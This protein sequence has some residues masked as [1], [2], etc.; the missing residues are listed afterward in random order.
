MDLDLAS[1]GGLELGLKIGPVKTSS[2]NYFE[3]GGRG[4]GVQTSPEVSSRVCQKSSPFILTVLAK[5]EGSTLSFQVGGGGK[6][7]PLPPGSPFHLSSDEYIV[8][9]TC[10][11]IIV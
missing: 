3:V 1:W 7:P 10:N 6:L 2:G 4:G 5:V 9:A 11:V 8:T